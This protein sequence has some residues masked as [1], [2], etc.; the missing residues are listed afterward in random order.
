MRSIHSF[1]DKHILAVHLPRLDVWF[2]KLTPNVGHKL[3]LVKHVCVTSEHR[4][5][6]IL[7]T[8]SVDGYQAIH[9][10]FLK[11][12]FIQLSLCKLL[13]IT[14]T[15]G[16]YWL[17]LRLNVLRLLLLT[18]NS[19]TCLLYLL[20]AILGFFRSTSSSNSF[21]FLKSALSI[22]LIR[23]P[24]SHYSRWQVI[25][26]LSKMVLADL[27]SCISLFLIPPLSLRWPHHVLAGTCVCLVAAW[28]SSVLRGAYRVKFQ[29]L[30]GSLCSIARVEGIWGG[31]VSAA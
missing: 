16:G 26:T 31:C 1:L 11:V 27:P 5:K 14:L 30:L 12:E 18:C 3:G 28:E 20:K 2:D 24:S 15:C 7:K 29:V 6:I 19:T 23:N 8:V 21:T 22:I 25:I 17:S 4:S 9:H 10:H 13:Q